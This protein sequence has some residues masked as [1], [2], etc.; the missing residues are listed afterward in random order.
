MHC[1]ICFKMEMPDYLDNSV[2]RDCKT[3]KLALLVSNGMEKLIVSHISGKKL[4][5]K[6]WNKLI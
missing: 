3:L 2:K 4:V 6:L 5:V 1:E